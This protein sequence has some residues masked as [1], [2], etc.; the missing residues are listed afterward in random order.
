VHARVYDDAGSAYDACHV[1]FCWS[2]EHRHPEFVLR[3]SMP[4]L[5][6]PLSTLRSDPRRSPRMRR[7]NYP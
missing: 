3:R 4:G 6:T 2:G 5:L 7:P 1:A